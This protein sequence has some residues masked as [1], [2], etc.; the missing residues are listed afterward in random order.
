MTATDP[1]PG[2]EARTAVDDGWTVERLR[3]AAE[4]AQVGTFAGDLLT[5]AL[6]WSPR[7]RAIF[8]VGADVVI[9][10]ADF[11]ALVHPD[12]AERVA[13][14]V[15][16]VRGPEEPG[17]YALEFRIVRPDGETRWV[18]SRGRVVYGEVEG[19]RRPLRFLGAVVDITERKRFQ[20]ELTEALAVKEALLEE[21]NHRVKNSLQLVTSLCSLQA[22]HA[23]D[24][25]VKRILAEASR[26]IGVIAA[27]H[28]RLYASRRHD[29]VDAADL[30]GG[31]ATDTVRALGDPERIG[32]SFDG[33][34]RP[35]TLAIDRAV[36]TAL[37]V[38][39][40][41]INALKYAYP[42]PRT[43]TVRLV[44]ADDGGG[45]L[46]I[47]VADDGV[48]LPEGYDPAESTGIGMR[49]VAALARQLGA[50]L[51]VADAAPGARFTLALPPA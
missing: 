45:A 48:G 34:P 6:D 25:G 40:M 2:S 29:R 35:A 47:T 32:F 20:E 37:I 9:T 26:R 19:A 18:E 23:V 49:I 21:V 11:E 28:E 31:L 13:E 30:L 8:G 51:D 12:D 4:A 38:N 15:R 44:L 36:P 5:G 39:E 17:A 27:V 41:L 46:R 1:P 50:T 24:A 10:R 22:G 43:G 33:P 16:R 14:A 3:L 7:C 42:P